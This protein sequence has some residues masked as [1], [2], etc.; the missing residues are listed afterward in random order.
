MR[1]NQNLRFQIKLHEG[2]R[3]KAYK[4]SLG[5]WTIGFGHLLGTRRTIQAITLA[6]AEMFIQED[7][8]TAIEHAKSFPWFERLS[9][10]RKFVVIDMMFNLGLVKF[11]KFK[12][13]VG[14]IAA[15]DY[16][17]AAGEMLDSTWSRQVGERAE[18]LQY[19]MLCDMD[20]HTA[21][22]LVP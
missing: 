22:S 11:R 21:L 10:N 1:D 17:R 12:L 8:A 19:M 20:F 9:E 4:D 2:L 13:T 16:D 14:Y 5:F 15:G 18:R 6:Q 3:L 7:L